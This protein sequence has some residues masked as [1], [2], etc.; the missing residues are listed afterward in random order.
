[1]RY[2]KKGHTTALPAGQGPAPGTVEDLLLFRESIV[3]LVMAGLLACNVS[4]VLPIPHVARQWTWIG[5]TFF[6][7]YS[8][9]TARDL[10]TVPF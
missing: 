7:T 8:C 4:A 1:M 10:H 3:Y 9:A 6:V 5:E 2:G